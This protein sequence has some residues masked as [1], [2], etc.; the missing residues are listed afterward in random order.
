MKRYWMLSMVTVSLLALAVVASANPGTR[1]HVN[2]PFAF[3]VDRAMLP[4]GQYVFEMKSVSPY[5]AAATSVLIRN[6]EGNIVHWISTIAGA[7]TNGT[8]LDRLLFN[9]YGD[10][11]FLARVES[12]EN[13][14]N[15]RKSTAE[16]ELMTQAVKTEETTLVALK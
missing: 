6:R 4:A 2:V 1:L 9:R 5:A 14:A 12:C 3:H 10:Q 7:R 11:Y 8:G 15:V 16:R 13:Q